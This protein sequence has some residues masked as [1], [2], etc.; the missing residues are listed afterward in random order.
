MQENSQFKTDFDEQKKLT[1]IQDA[2]ILGD[3]KNIDQLQFKIKELE[4]THTEKIKE[5]KEEQH[6]VR[7]PKKKKVHFGCQ[8]GITRLINY[9]L[10]KLMI[11]CGLS[12]RSW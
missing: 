12:C 9:L 8:A 3:R 10:V 6:K 1:E 4:R 7:T 11:F 2:K 5:L